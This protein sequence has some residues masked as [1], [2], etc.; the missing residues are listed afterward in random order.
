MGFMDSG[1]FGTKLA[2]DEEYVPVNEGG[3]GNPF[4]G[5]KKRK[6]KIVVG[7]VAEP[8][9]IKKEAIRG[10]Q[11]LSYLKPPKQE[12]KWWIKQPISPEELAQEPK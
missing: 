5:R 12:N 11:D 7:A 3:V 6:K 1:L 2:A 8:I 10:N 4:T 9:K